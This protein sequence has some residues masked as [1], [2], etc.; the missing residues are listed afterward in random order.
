M[1]RVKKV[2]R[3]QAVLMLR[4]MASKIDGEFI[5]G[6]YHTVATELGWDHG[7]FWRESPAIKLAYDAYMEARRRRPSWEVDIA[8]GQGEIDIYFRSLEALAAEILEEGW[9]PS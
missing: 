1:S 6:Y 9:R 4:I 8:P 7:D 3:D 5:Q 2:H